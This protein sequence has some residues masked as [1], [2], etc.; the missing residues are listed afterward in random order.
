MPY[1]ITFGVEL[2]VKK[3]DCRF[4]IN[5]SQFYEHPNTKHSAIKQESE[6]E[7]HNYTEDCTCKVM[8]LEIFNDTGNP[9]AK[10][11]KE[12]CKILVFQF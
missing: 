10:G 11:K 1:S 8:R 9:N 12:I 5:G 4:L 6:D 2:L 3:S 7:H